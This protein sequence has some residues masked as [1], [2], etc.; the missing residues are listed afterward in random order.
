MTSTSRL[1]LDIRTG[2]PA[3]PDIP[4]PRKPMR[5]V[6]GIR[7]A[8]DIDD[9]PEVDHACLQLNSRPPS[10]SFVP[11]GLAEDVAGGAAARR[12]RETRRGNWCRH[13][14]RFLF[15]VTSGVNRGKKLRTWE[16]TE[17]GLV[18]T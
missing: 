15:W 5:A 16:A 12:P 9:G 17:L 6:D 13:M 10:L 3:T 14:D 7:A 4:A 11:V 8:A 18:I 1:P 2:W